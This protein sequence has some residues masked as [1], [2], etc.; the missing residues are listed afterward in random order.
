MKR[1]LPPPAPAARR[2]AILAA[3]IAATGWWYAHRPLALAAE[4]VDFTVAR[5]MGMR[6]PL[7]PSSA[8][9][10]A[11]MRACSLLARLTKRDARI[12][13]GSYG[14]HAPASRPAAHPQALRRRRHAGR[15]VAG[16]G[17]DLPPGAPGSSPIRTWKPTPPAGRGRRSAHRRERRT[18]RAS[19]SPIPI[20]ST[21]ARARSPCCDARIEA[22][23]A[24]LDK[25][26]AERDPAT[27]LASAL[28]GADPRLDRREGDRPPGTAPWSPRC[29]P[30]GCASACACRPT[31][32]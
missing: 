18:P 27:P 20:C 32:R 26:W 15:A 8:P 5:G 29:S 13:A 1:F 6:R 17:L 23:Q 28:R 21:S 4:R 25:A 14:V 19:S 24:C 31:R 2:A 12:K 3:M 30:T 7:P 10:W 11:W 16:R 9:A 22:M